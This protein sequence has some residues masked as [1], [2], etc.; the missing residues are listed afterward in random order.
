MRKKSCWKA[1]V[2]DEEEENWS[3]KKATLVVGTGK[4]AVY[5]FPT[6]SNDLSLWAKALIL[7]QKPGLTL[8]QFVLGLESHF[9]G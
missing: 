5:L 7:F 9:E 3:R 2:G 1:G 8:F 6:E 4:R